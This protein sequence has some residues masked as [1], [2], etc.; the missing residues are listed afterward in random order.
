MRA[1]RVE[2]FSNRNPFDPIIQELLD[3]GVFLPL[4]DKDSNGCQ[5]FIIRTGAHSA[6][7]HQQNDVLKVGCR[8]LIDETKLTII[9]CAYVFYFRWHGSRV[10]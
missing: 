7:K 2:W 8:S 10:K 6:K 1:E 5:I 3:I 4:K 9:V